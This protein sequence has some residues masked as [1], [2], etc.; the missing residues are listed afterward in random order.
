[1]PIAVLI[2]L[3]RE[4]FIG[5]RL[6][7]FAGAVAEVGLSERAREPI[8][9]RQVGNPSLPS[10]RRSTQEQDGLRGTDIRPVG[11]A[12]QFDGGGRSYSSSLILLTK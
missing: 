1:V 12:A 8:I 6:D 4:A 3:R 5:V 10:C 9:T 7:A 11:N 2:P